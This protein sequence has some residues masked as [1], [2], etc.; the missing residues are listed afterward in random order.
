MLESGSLLGDRYLIS[1]V[2]GSGHFSTVYLAQDQR[3]ADKFVAVKE[4]NPNT[5]SPEDRE[6][7]RETIRHEAHLRA[8]LAS[9][10]HLADVTDYFEAD[11]RE[12]LVI[13][14]VDGDTL[15]QQWE[16]QP[17]RRFDQQQVLTW[18]SQL[19]SAL[20]F[21]HSHDPPVV[22][23]DLK[24]E[25]II[26]R[27]DGT[28]K[29]IDFGIARFHSGEQ[30]KDTVNLGTHGYAAPEQYGRAESDARTD[31]YA[32]GV[33]L[34]QLLS[35]RDPAQHAF[36]MPSLEEE[37]PDIS[38]S[39]AKA[40]DQAMNPDPNARF[41][42]ARALAGA[43]GVPFSG[44]LQDTPP[45]PTPQ[46][47][48]LSRPVLVVVGLLLLLVVAG[49][50]L[51]AW[52]E[53]GSDSDGEPRP[54]V[55]VAGATSEP[56]E[57]GMIGL[58]DPEGDEE[59]SGNRTPSTGTE[60]ATSTSTSTPTETPSPTNTLTPV[61]TVTATATP[62]DTPNPTDTPEPALLTYQSRPIV[63]DSTRNGSST[64]VFIMDWDGGNVRQLTNS[65]AT[66]E[67]ADLSPDGSQIAYERQA[68]NDWYIYV[69]NVDGSNQSRLFAG[70]EPDWS[71]DGRYLAYE[72]PVPE[73]IMI[74]DFESGGVR[75]LYGS[76]RRD[77]AP[78]WS[79]DGQRIAFMSEVS[80]YWQLFTVNVGTG[81]GDQVTSDAVNKRFPV[82]SP[83]GELLAYNSIEGG[84][85]HIWT[86]QPDGSEPRRLT[87]R[88][89]N[90]RPA[91]S[92]D[93][94]YIIFNSNRSGAW[95]IWRMDRNGANPQQ[96]S[97]EGA[98]FSDQ[99]PDWGAHRLGE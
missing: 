56:S 21:L 50:V 47:T 96:L 81:E 89:S 87:N 65:S 91:W 31:I 67:E 7:A 49:G 64:N 18:A 29:L 83:D 53:M 17:G 84:D 32:L 99:R 22:Y 72:S 35:G 59:G 11:G 10:P 38:P 80:G 95:R 39:V 19:L 51:V 66:E 9:H 16:Q 61:K 28:L 60:T 13:E 33:L 63:F 78:S 79:P 1:R 70:R 46:R 25:N 93:G 15:R 45:P 20:H 8:R 77:R 74:Y 40:I 12:Y 26:V 92:P 90:G 2:L 5:F 69:M 36:N 86:I 44:T 23:R 43:L 58:S 71:P 30:E 41:R 37:R 54:P 24:P 75:E 52:G 14:Y 27:P 68:G 82:W 55:Q 34:H 73:D 48:R 94:V 3:L 97:P 76:A 98:G 42:S 6:W 62:T 85:F 57:E 88:N 4:F